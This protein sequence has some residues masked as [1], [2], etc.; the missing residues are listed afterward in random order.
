MYS[1][2]NFR[3]YLVSSILIIFLLL[4]LF[5]YLRT[6]IF[7]FYTIHTSVFLFSYP[8]LCFIFISFLDWRAEVGLPIEFEYLPDDVLCKQLR[9]FYAELS[10][11]EGKQYSKSSL[12][13]IRGALHRHLTGPSYQRVVNIIS[14]PA[15]KCA[16]DVLTG[17]IKKLKKEGLDMSASHPPIK[18][19]DIKLMYSSGT[20][21]DDNPTGLQLKVYFEF[22]LHFG[23]RGREG[24]RELQKKPFSFKMD[25]IGNEYA[26]LT[27][28]PLEKN[29]Q[30]VSLH[31]IEHG[32][33][34]Y[35]TGGEL[36]PLRS[37]KKYLNL[38]NPDLEDFFQRPKI[39]GYEGENIWYMKL[40][41]GVNTIGKFM[42]IISR[43]AGLSYPYTNHCV[44]STTVT[45]LQ[46]QGVSPLD[47]MA[48][49]GHKSE[50]S[51]NHYSATSDAKRRQMS[52]KLS[53]KSGYSVQIPSESSHKNTPSA[54]AGAPPPVKP[55]KQNRHCDTDFDTKPD[56]SR[57][58][59]KDSPLHNS[60]LGL[61]DLNPDFLESS[62]EEDIEIPC[63]QI[64]SNTKSKSN[65]HVNIGMSFRN[66]LGYSPVFN[67]CSIN[68]YQK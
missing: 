30:G 45:T 57:P 37:L 43:P 31:E 6:L 66:L 17:K 29:H 23:R 20:L 39:T 25:E 5:L 54:T 44:R 41:V 19:A 67:N 38:L 42:S 47:I 3:P 52:H 55:A 28:N 10:N 8:F 65:A 46:N 27:H 49:T 51:I 34:M 22:C 48:V 40:P 33:R 50:A 62:E 15:F 4:Q 59:L 16:N 18:D 1:I 14:G 12:I 35:S 68:I 2:I 53:E 56:I 9:K 21:T 32:Q 36:C 61:F 60:A 7:R 13:C 24:L 58:K 26:T 11:Q 64:V 63:S